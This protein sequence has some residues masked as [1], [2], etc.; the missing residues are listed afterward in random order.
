MAT[1]G[2]VS[3]ACPAQGCTFSN[4]AL[5]TVKRHIEAEHPDEVGYLRGQIVRN[6]KRKKK[7]E[8]KEEWE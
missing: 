3:I 2:D 1:H 6:K 8:V 7:G 4:T 5:S